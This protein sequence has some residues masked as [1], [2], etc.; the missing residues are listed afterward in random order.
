MAKKFFDGLKRFL[1]KIRGN[2]KAATTVKPFGLEQLEQ[3]GKTF[4]LTKGTYKIAKAT[5]E[6][7]GHPQTVV[8]DL[9][10]KKNRTLS[11]LGYFRAEEVS[12]QK[13]IEA[14]QSKLKNIADCIVT[15]NTELDYVNQVEKIIE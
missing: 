5:L 6:A 12:I 11:A 10:V 8:E 15:T 7:C 13:K 3:V 9:T 4:G 2:A 1:T 14:L